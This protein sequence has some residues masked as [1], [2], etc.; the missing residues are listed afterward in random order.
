[1]KERVTKIQEVPESLKA[2]MF[3]KPTFLD[4]LSNK[5]AKKQLISKLACALQA[6]PKKCLIY[7]VDDFN[8]KYGQ[9]YSNLKKCFTYIRVTLKQ[10]G[11]KHP[12]LFV[13]EGRVY[14]WNNEV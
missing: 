4:M 10:L 3:E 14:I 6:E 12:R 1:M 11:L 8:Q 2:N 5:G 13:D 9:G 7:T